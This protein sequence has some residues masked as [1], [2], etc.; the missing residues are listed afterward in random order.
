M[1]QSRR[2]IL[3]AAVVLAAI[4]AVPHSASAQEATAPGGMQIFVT[5]Y[6]WQCIRPTIAV[7]RGM[8]NFSCPFPVN[9]SRFP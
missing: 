3:S 8:E 2:P 5:P 4:G 7:S 9:G 1:R 6:L